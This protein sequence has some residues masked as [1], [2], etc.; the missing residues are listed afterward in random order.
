MTKRTAIVLFN[1]GGP[2]SLEAVRPFLFNLFNDKA[3][4]HLPQPFRAL[5]AAFVAKRRAST[6]VEIYRHL[7][8]GS[9]L[10]EN[11][12]AQ[13]N[14]L[15]MALGGGPQVRVF[16]A[17]RY[18]HPFTEQTVSD[19][20]GWRPDEIVLLPLYPQFS[21]TTTASSVLAWRQ[22]ARALKLNVPTRSICC[23]PEAPGFIRAAVDL[24][25]PA[26]AQAKTYG[27][28][29][30]LLSAHGL[31]E[32]VVKGGDPYQIQCEMTAKAIVSA[33]GQPDLDWSLC[34]QSR[35]GP[36]KWI[37]PST[38]EEI[39]RAGQDKVPVVIAP[40]AFVSEH[41][42]T[43]V[44]IEIEY[45]KLAGDVGVPYFRR[46]PTVA[47]A[48]SFIETLANLVVKEPAGGDVTSDAGVRICPGKCG[49]CPMKL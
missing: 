16:V 7:G 49:A 21:T 28:P 34:Y 46:V 39:R 26:L 24:I 1:L 19:V 37:G 44:E 27:H 23:Y 31:P 4:F 5:L 17:M 15:H 13:A 2:D 35:V 30:L 40:V 14:A 22:S 38:G 47:T 33:I 36:M 41:S 48:P 45:R 11:T 43:L 3:I 29:R 10:L 25:E 6:A 8:G 32:T 9:P 12:E 42:E 18:W 20:Q